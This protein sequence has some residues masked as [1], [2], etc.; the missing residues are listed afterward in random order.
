[1]HFHRIYALIMII[2][3]GPRAVIDAELV[4]I[5]N[6]RPFTLVVTSDSWRV[7]R[8]QPI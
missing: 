1:M 6:R 2:A 8:R 3:L 5:D 7:T 4:C